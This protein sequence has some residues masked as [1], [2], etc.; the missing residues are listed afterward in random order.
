[1]TQRPLI[2][3]AGGGSAG[4]LSPALAIIEQIGAIAPHIDVAILAADRPVDRTVLDPTGLPWRAQ[5]VRP[6]PAK[7]TQWPGFLKTWIQSKRRARADF[8]A[9]QIGR[10]SCRERV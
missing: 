10:A 4:H 7:P 6:F 1:M 3:F 2:V 5:S 9:R 8:A